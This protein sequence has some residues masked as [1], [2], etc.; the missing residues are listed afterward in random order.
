MGD[1]KL[2]ITTERKNIYF[3]LPKDDGINLKYEAPSIIKHINFKIR[4]DNYC[5]NISMGKILMN[6]EKL[7]RINYINLFFYCHKLKL[8][9][10]KFLCYLFD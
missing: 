10:K 1:N 8:L 3:D 5:S 7:T 9:S 2:E 6:T 4:L